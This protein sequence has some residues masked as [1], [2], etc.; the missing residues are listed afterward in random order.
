[1]RNAW[2]HETSGE[3]QTGCFFVFLL[4]RRQYSLIRFIHLPLFHPLLTSLLDQTADGYYSPWSLFTYHLGNIILTLYQ[5]EA[6]E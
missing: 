5:C 1:M 6:A 2:L 4:T 3:A